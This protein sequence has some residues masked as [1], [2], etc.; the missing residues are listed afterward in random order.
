MIATTTDIKDLALRSLE[1]MR[2]G[3]LADFEDLIHPDAVNREA[4]GSSRG[5]SPLQKETACGC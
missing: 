2:D 4:L 5:A 1:I 3:S